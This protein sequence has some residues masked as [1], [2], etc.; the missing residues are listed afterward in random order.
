M[1]LRQ[2]GQL[3]NFTKR[4]QITR[5]NRKSVLFGA[6]IWKV[7]GRMPIIIR[8]FLKKKIIQNQFSFWK[9][10][11]LPW[12][13]IVRAYHGWLPCLPRTELVLSQDKVRINRVLVRF[14]KGISLE[15]S[16]LTVR[17]MFGFLNPREGLEICHIYE[18]LDKCS[19]LVHL[20][21]CHLRSQESWFQPS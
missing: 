5:C 1:Q 21:L 18:L 16:K 17:E 13:A 12:E 11:S 7:G 8:F 10:S 2:W 6:E 15:E 19:L 3:G 9:T 14:C 20:F 4:M